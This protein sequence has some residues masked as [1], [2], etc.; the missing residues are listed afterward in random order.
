MKAP[1]N[2]HLIGYYCTP[3]RYKLQH[4][5]PLGEENDTKFALQHD[6]T[7]IFSAIISNIIIITIIIRVG[8]VGN[9][10]KS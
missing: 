10:S 7:N 2:K 5:V 8:V 3:V 9:P 4:A 1:R 6:I